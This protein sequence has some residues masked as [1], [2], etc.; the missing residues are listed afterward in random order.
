MMWF[1]DQY[2]SDPRERVQSTDSPLRATTDELRGLLPALIITAEAIVLCD[3]GEAY[4]N[5]LR[6]AGGCTTA[7]RFQDIMH[8]FV[9]LNALATTA[10][11]RG[12]IALATVWLW[13]GFAGQYARPRPSPGQRT[14]SAWGSEGPLC[15][16]ERCLSS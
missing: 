9:M 14:T 15:R 11:T 8:E 10:A 3:E 12:A 6:H 5:K 1:W 7:A 2:T 16:L 13:D 4:A